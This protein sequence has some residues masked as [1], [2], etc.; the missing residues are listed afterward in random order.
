MYSSMIFLLPMLM[1]RFAKWNKFQE[2]TG[3]WAAGPAESSWSTA[4]SV[5]P[6][7]HQSW[8]FPALVTEVSPVIIQCHW[9]WHDLTMTI[10][11]YGDARGSPMKKRP[12][13]TLQAVVNMHGHVGRTAMIIKLRSCVWFI[14]H[15]WSRTLTNPQPSRRTTCVA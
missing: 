14:G 6:H 11:T 10:E 5:W 13:E 7:C 2:A 1:F 15:K 8:S 3:N 12:N 9:T 4:T